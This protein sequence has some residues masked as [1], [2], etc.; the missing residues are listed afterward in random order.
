MNLNH[1]NPDYDFSQM[2][3]EPNRAKAIE[4]LAKS[5]PDHMT[6]RASHSCS[7]PVRVRTRNAE[8]KSQKHNKR[9]TAEG[10]EKQI[11][12]CLEMLH[13]LAQ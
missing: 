3:N 6:A 1:F 13:I 7:F 12:H 4:V 2:I 10:D 9:A 5:L 8:L 11:V